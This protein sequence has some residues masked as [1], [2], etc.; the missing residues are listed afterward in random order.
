MASDE[1][2]GVGICLAS[3]GC[4]NMLWIVKI[5]SL[6]LY[7]YQWYDSGW[8]TEF[9]KSNIKITTKTGKIKNNKTVNPKNIIFGRVQFIS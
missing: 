6:N 4:I 1:A 3:I 7:P 8:L 5:Y 2:V 9:L